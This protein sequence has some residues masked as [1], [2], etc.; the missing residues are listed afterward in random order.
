MSNLT[1]EQ[2][3]WEIV[4]HDPRYPI[5]AYQFV[6]EALHHTQESLGK[7]NHPS[8]EPATE[9]ER[10]ISGE[11]LL[12]G[13][14]DLAKIEFGFLARVVFRQWGVQR[15]DDVGEI[16]FNMI[17]AGLLSKTDRD[18]RDDFHNLF[19]MD[20]ALGEGLTIEVGDVTRSKRGTR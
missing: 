12:L 19:N 15:T 9:V 2:S 14:C 5:E 1:T 17:E 16:V 18:S 4:R 11:E 10:H 20:R 13:V 7:T 3:I 8:R 6:L